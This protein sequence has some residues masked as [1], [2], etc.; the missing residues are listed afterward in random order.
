MNWLEE[1]ETLLQGTGKCL[2]TQSL[3]EQHGQDFTY[4]K[5]HLPDV[6]VYPESTEEVASI[7]RFA[8]THFIPVV[9]FGAGSSLEGHI[10]PVQGGISLDMTRMNQIIEILPNDFMV[11][12]QPGVTLSQLNQALMPHG[13]FFP[14]D[15]GADAT[16]G[17]MA[18]TNASG[19]N[20]V[21]Y[22]A[23]RDQV[24][25]LQ[26]VLADGR[27]LK[28]GGLVVKSSAG[29]NLTNL[30]V[31]S[32]GTLGVFT[33]ITLRI[34]GIPEY[35]MAARAVFPNIDTAG[36]AAI[37]MVGAGLFIGRVELVDAGTIAAVNAYKG[38]SYEEQETLFLEFSGSESSVQHAVQIAK[39]LCM[40]SGC[41]QF[42]FEADRKARARLWDARHQAAI[43]LMAQEPGKRM[44]V[45]DVCVPI[46]KLPNALHHA[47][48]VIQ[49]YG[50]HG[51]ILG[52]V[53]DGNYH[54]GFMVNPDD[55][56][57]I[58]RLQKVN[59]EIVHYALERNGT[60]TGEHGLG[61]GK[62]KYLEE[63]FGLDAVQVM[64]E[65]KR[66]F[67]PHEILNPGKGV[68]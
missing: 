4:H 3:L 23:M 12:V 20:A 16:I 7:L 17:G 26:V 55:P 31:G 5:A 28:T 35:T 36:R 10:I 14:V 19:T 18:S 30:F 24:K 13:L 68:L 32:E 64:K 63:E 53:G 9:P 60:C 61:L 15:P 21:R 65:L 67:D 66:M 52:H 57:D 2:R 39:E 8:N 29:Y 37:S 58:E 1:L 6:V 45:T 44:M 56:T 48:Q 11:R 27:V 50:L 47:R 46:T 40:D 33:E 51:F 38:T 42:L 41:T 25:G 54:A 49:K 34:H 59:G 22:G 43:A 62:G